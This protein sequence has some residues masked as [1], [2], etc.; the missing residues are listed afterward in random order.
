MPANITSYVVRPGLPIWPYPVTFSDQVIAA[1]K[2]VSMT[3]RV[4][5]ISD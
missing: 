4:E 1:V 2:A 3:E 5:V